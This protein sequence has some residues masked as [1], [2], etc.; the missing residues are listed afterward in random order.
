MVQQKK[1]IFGLFGEIPMTTGSII[2]KRL[3]TALKV[4]LLAVAVRARIFTPD[5]ITLRK[6]PISAKAR[7]KSSP[8]G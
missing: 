5:G 6:V 1:K 2:A 8:T 4:D 7:R 3:T